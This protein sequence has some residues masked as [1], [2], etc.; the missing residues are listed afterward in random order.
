M[1]APALTPAAA[2][3]IVP[4]RYAKGKM[5]IVPTRDGSG[6]KGRAARLAGTFGRWVNRSGGYTVSEAGARRFERLY[7][8]GW[9][10]SIFGDL[11]APR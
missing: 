6:F 3:S 10:A 11:E 9:D 1:T 5:V 7:T 4:A 8:E 2:Y